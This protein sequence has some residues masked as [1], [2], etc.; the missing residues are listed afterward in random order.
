MRG[1]NKTLK[2]TLPTSAEKS[3]NFSAEVWQ[4]LTR[5][6]T[7][8][9]VADFAPAVNLAKG[10]VLRGKRTRSVSCRLLI[11]I[12]CSGSQNVVASAILSGEDAF[13]RE[14]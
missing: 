3:G 10:R 6:F 4:L 11:E 8:R 14:L 9:R 7:S 1:V 13:A 12:V 2:R 5:S